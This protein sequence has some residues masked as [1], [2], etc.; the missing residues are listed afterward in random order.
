[1]SN[2]FRQFQGFVVRVAIIEV[3][4]DIFGSNT[5]IELQTRKKKKQ[6]RKN[7]EYYGIPALREMSREVEIYII[8]KEYYRRKYLKQTIHMSKPKTKEYFLQVYTKNV[9]NYIT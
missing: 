9:T 2:W 7:R 4:V 8:E 3:V 6:S 1:M 5:K